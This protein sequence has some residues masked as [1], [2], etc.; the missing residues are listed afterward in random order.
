[1]I[2]EGTTH[3]W[4]PA[5]QRPMI[6]NW[7]F[8]RAYYKDSPQGWYSFSKF[9]EWCHTQN[10]LEWFEEETAQ[11]YFVPIEVF[12]NPTFTPKREEV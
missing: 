1:M 6:S 12:I 2:P 8:R 11:G 3:V 4:T 10:D 9:G 7:I 5:V